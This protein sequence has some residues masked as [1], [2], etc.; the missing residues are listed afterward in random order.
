LSKKIIVYFLYN[1]TPKNNK[2]TVSTTRGVI[3]TAPI[4]I[5]HNNTL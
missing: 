4:V 1:K 3:A 2:N 5:S